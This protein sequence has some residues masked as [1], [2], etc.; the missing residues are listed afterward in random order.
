ML[1]HMME[2]LCLIK[3]GNAN[4][5]VEERQRDVHRSDIKLGT[6]E[7][8]KNNAGGKH[9]QNKRTA[10]HAVGTASCRARIH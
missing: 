3:L 10:V 6:R 5:H 4:I 8:E 2:N 7:N 9:A 1:L